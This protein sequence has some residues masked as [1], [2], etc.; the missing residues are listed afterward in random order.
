MVVNVQSFLMI[1]N[2]LPNNQIIGNIDLIH[3]NKPEYRTANAS[4]LH[5]KGVTRYGFGR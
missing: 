3:T 5:V 1:E 4:R 2:S